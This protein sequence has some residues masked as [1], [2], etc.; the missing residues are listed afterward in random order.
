MDRQPYCSHHGIT[1]QLTI[2][3]TPEQN[4]RAERTNRTIIEG[5]IAL[6]QHSGLPMTLW[7]EALRYVVDT[8]N[9]SPHSAIDHKI[10]DTIWYGKPPSTA[11][12]RAFGCRA[13]HTTPQHK[14]AKLDP[15]AKPFIF[16][17]IENKT[18][19][20][21]L[22]DPETIS[23]FQSCD[24]RFD[25]NIFP[26][27]DAPTGLL[28]FILLQAFEHF[29]IGPPFVR[30]RQ[31]AITTLMFH[32]PSRASPMHDTRSSQPLTCRPGLPRSPTLDHGR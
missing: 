1:R 14:R 31:L 25:E 22:Y 7:R 5:T 16:V 19:A 20:W 21:T 15:K 3:Y 29:N 24:V 30:H 6:L 4:G 26:A 8:K 11:N 27:R 10:P 17:G 28:N 2:P 23:F 13:W 32:R 9:L 12:L 18:K